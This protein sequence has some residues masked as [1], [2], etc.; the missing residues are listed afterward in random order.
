LSQRD[1]QSC[2]CPICREY[3]ESKKYSTLVRSILHRNCT[4]CPPDCGDHDDN[5]DC[6]HCAGDSSCD[7][8][9]QA[10]EE[11]RDALKRFDEAKA[12]YEPHRELYKHQD[13]QYR[14]MKDTLTD[15]H[16]M[17]VCDFSPYN[18]TALQLTQ[19]ESRQSGMQVLHIVVIRR[20][21]KD[22]SATSTGT[23]TET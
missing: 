16:A 19:E 21:T 20:S 4:R 1:F 10:T 22:V 9:Q 11:Q 23:T 3:V 2:I 5:N 13:K 17:I 8:E 18:A 6:D 12:A 7:V 14:T 15:D